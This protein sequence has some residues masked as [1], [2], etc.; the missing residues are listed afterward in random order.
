MKTAKAICIAIIGLLVFQ[1]LMSSEAAAS[2]RA[3]PTT[4]LAYTSLPTPVRIADTRAG[5]TD[6]TTYAGRTLGPGASLTVDMPSSVPSNAGA[7]VAQLTAI[8]P[9][10]GGYLAVYPTGGAVPS[11]A[12][13]NFVAG[14]IVGNMVTVALGTDTA[15]ESP[16]VSIYNGPSGNTDFTLDLYGYYAPQTSTSG[17][18]YVPIAP[19]RIADTRPGSVYAG[20]GQTLGAG[21]TLDIPVTGANGVPSNASAVVVNI[22]VVNTT[23]QSYIQGYPTGSAPSSSTPTVNENWLAGEVLSTKAIIGVG[24][25]GAISLY[26][27]VGSTDVVADLDGY[28]TAAG[29]TGDLF[30]TLPSPV[31]LADTRSST[32]VAAGANLSVSV[33]GS[34]GIPASAVAGVLNVTDIPS[35][36]NYLT[37]YPSGQAVPTATDVNY[38]SGDTSSIVGNASYAT[39]G[40]SGAIDIYNSTSSANVVVDA[41]GY[42]SGVQVFTLNFTQSPT[43]AFDITYAYSVSSSS[44]SL[45][46][47]VLDLYSSEIGAPSGS[48]LECSLSV[49]GSVLGGTCPVMYTSTA[50]PG[51]ATV[52]VEYQSGTSAASKTFTE[53]IN[54]FA[55]TTTQAITASGST[56]TDAVSVIDQNGNTVPQ[57]WDRSIVVITDTTNGAIYWNLPQNLSQ[58]DLTCAFTLSGSSL[59]ISGCQ[60]GVY[61]PIT[62]T[63]I[64][65]QTDTI[66]PADHFTIQAG[67]GALS[68]DEPA[69]GY[70]SSTS[71]L[72]PIVF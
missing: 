1:A 19:T 3:I 63:Y 15:T 35:G 68:G 32:A 14:Q 69:P 6:P 34:N 9:P 58:P 42:F 38:T 26:N 39:V 70:A 54:P 16:A 66:N 43:N 49:G 20:A 72:V 30:N 71:P 40:T 25:G 37:V 46:N 56:T 13:V 60:G 50:L 5:A 64:P 57:W 23:A 28:F 45:P 4:N 53:M 65:S 52:I 24:T 47:G 31:R 33:A 2:S 12:N 61:E 21:G 29:A 59:S 41:F 27:A 17:A 10:L 11:T 18:A 44:G 22:A 7:I 8:N 51:S 48:T 36:P 55:T 62:N 67:Y